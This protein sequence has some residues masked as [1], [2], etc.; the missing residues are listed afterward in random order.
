MIA[1]LAPRL[2]GERVE[3][4]EDPI[5]ARRTVL[6]MKDYSARLADGITV[7]AFRMS[8]TQNGF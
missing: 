1:P 3:L 7:T 2:H 4:D 5:R 8:N 6:G